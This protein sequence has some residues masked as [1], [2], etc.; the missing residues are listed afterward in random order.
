LETLYVVFKIS[1][2][3]RNIARSVLKSPK[4]Y[5]YDTGQVPDEPGM[6]LENL[7]ACSM[8]K[9]MHFREDCFGEK[10]GLYYLR[11]KDRREIDFLVTKEEMPALA[12]EV[13]WGDA[14]KSPNFAHFEKYLGRIRKIQIVKQLKR[15]KTY[16]DGTEI[17][18]A[19]QWLSQ[20]NL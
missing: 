20:I 17:R 3:H 1:P 15:E 19:A 11:N 7:V 6:R 12:I 9:E 14:E 8:L 10:W 16:P 2:F 18:S 4:Y 5:F 13:K